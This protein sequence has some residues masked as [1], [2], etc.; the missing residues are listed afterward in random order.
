MEKSKPAKHRCNC[1]SE[2]SSSFLYG[3]RREGPSTERVVLERLLN[4]LSRAAVETPKN[5]QRLWSEEPDWWKECTKLPW[6]N[7]REHPKDKKDTLKQKIEI[8]EKQLRER[9][10]MTPAIEQEL[11]LSKSGKKADLELKSDF[12]AVI[13]K[14]SGLHYMVNQVYDKMSKAHVFSDKIAVYVRETKSCL[15]QCLTS[16]SKLFQRV[17][18]R[19][20]R[21]QS[22]WDKMGVSQSKRIRP[23]SGDFPLDELG[24]VAT[25]IQDNLLSL[26]DTQADVYS[27]SPP[28]L[29]PAPFVAE[30]V[31]SP[32]SVE[33]AQFVPPKTQ[34]TYQR[35]ASE[36]Y[37]TPAFTSVVTS[38]SVH[39]QQRSVSVATLTPSVLETIKASDIAQA[40]QPTFPG[41]ININVVKPLVHRRCASQSLPV[42]E[43]VRESAREGV[44][45]GFTVDK[46]I[47]VRRQE[48]AVSFNIPATDTVHAY[49][50]DGIV[51]RGPSTTRQ[52]KRL[53][54]AKSWGG[55]MF[56]SG[57]PGG[58]Q[59]ETS[60]RE[61]Y[62]QSTV[63][64]DPV[65][66][67]THYG[68]GL[69]QN[70]NYKPVDTFVSD[71]SNPMVIRGTLQ[72]IPMSPN[73]SQDL[74]LSVVDDGDGTVTIEEPFEINGM[75]VIEVTPV[76]SR[77]VL[78]LVSGETQEQ[79]V[80]EH[81]MAVP[82]SSTSREYVPGI[83][84]V[85]VDQLESDMHKT[86]SLGEIQPTVTDVIM[87]GLS[88][89]GTTSRS[90]SSKS[91]SRRRKSSSSTVLPVREAEQKGTGASPESLSSAIGKFSVF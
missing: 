16:V 41:N 59:T 58:V 18:S 68:S 29:S 14:A 15:E 52:Q 82:V 81:D 55:D 51:L 57:L 76:H 19:E 85:G 88:G 79:V 9:G 66:H 7:P 64:E 65:I 53:S 67:L 26:P 22:L 80:R 75:Q 38:D 6:K 77:N 60:V 36:P 45:T 86:L 8:L 50:H 83:G 71:E 72:G 84:M 20:K 39:S 11:E 32:P 33:T 4:V 56:L 78:T 3:L 42:L 28:I 48:T 63:T 90:R 31:K 12:E 89:D 44:N 21:K 2:E 47:S 69:E 73:S 10:L 25:F 43:S 27:L 37:P 35:S 40:T 23:A 24:E 91:C 5:P 1:F 70:F 34:N 49:S 54:R 61:T 46:G 87:R 30:E 62:S 13:A 74:Q 17:E